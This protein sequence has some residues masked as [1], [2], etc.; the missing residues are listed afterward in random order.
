M[1]TAIRFRDR[2][3]DSGALPLSSLLLPPSSNY[4]LT[5]LWIF[6]GGLVKKAY[7]CILKVNNRQ[8]GDSSE[9]RI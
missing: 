3:Y 4:F 9:S 2:R 1:A 8:Y 6:L 5:F 7:L